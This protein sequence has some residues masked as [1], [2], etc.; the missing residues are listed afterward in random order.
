M[1]TKAIEQKNSF[2]YEDYM[3]RPDN[4]RWEILD[5]TPIMMAPPSRVHQKI[6]VELL[7]QFS[8][9]LRDKTCEVYPAPFGVRLPKGYEKD[10]NEIQT[11]V[12]PDIAV[13]CDKN[14]LDDKGCK[15]AP[16]LIIEVVSPSSA[17]I[18]KLI[19]FNK[20]EKSGVKEYWIIEPEAKIVS[21]FTLGE[22]GRYGRP[23]IY[24]DNDNIKVGIFEDLVIKLERVFDY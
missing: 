21:I 13:I 12:E 3:N 9:Y 8:T 5:G 14:K 17:K 15:G 1:V 7:T 22:N 6:L 20:Y 18:D 2:T 24:S 10:D 16:D 11:V 4:E 19:K 23:D